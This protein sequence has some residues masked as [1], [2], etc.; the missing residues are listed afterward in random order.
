VRAPHE[1]QHAA[2]DVAEPVYHPTSDRTM[3]LACWN[4]R[5]NASQFEKAV[6]VGTLQRVHCESRV[7]G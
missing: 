7:R 3:P 4:G 5:L 1:S 2:R 6:C